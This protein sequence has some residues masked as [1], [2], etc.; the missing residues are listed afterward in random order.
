MTT[1]K[2]NRV[3]SR[4]DKK[5]QGQSVRQQGPEKSRGD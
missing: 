5:K 2:I 3:G 4:R 1:P